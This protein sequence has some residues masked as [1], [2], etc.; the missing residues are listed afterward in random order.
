MEMILSDAAAKAD[1]NA[2]YFAAQLRCLIVRK[3]A[4]DKAGLV[5]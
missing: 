2:E 1:I 5:A 4:G 3:W